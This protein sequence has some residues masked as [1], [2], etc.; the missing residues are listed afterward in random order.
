LRDTPKPAGQL[1]NG[2]PRELDRLIE[3]CLRK[4]PARRFQSMLDLKVVL[5]DLKQ[6][7]ESGTLFTTPPQ[8]PLRRRPAWVYPVAALCV[9]LLVAGGW[10]FAR[11]S[12]GAPEPELKITAF[13]YNAGLQNWPT[14]SPDGRQ[15]AY[16]WNGEK[17][18]NPDI[19]VKMIST[20]TQLRLTSDPAPDAT[21]AWSPDGNYIAFVRRSSPDRETVLLISPLGG[22]ER[23]VADFPGTF[24]MDW[25]PDGKWL[26]I[27][28]KGRPE[29]A[30]S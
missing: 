7:S 8:L 29:E 1:S 21:P 24:G 23:K 17:Q 6:D 12:K 14:F 16:V 26:A 15:V 10:M 27:A 4:D 18:D 13:T 19:Y 20:G 3:R 11:R 28:A 5:E 2:V 30:Y 9:A 25:S 22:G